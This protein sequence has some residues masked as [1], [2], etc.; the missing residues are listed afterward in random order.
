VGADEYY[1]LISQAVAAT[2]SCADYGFRNN[3]GSLAIFAAI[4]RTS[5]FVSSLAAARSM[6]S[7]KRQRDGQRFRNASKLLH[8]NRAAT[9]INAITILMRPKPIMTRLE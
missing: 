2:T 3:S 9:V 7:L 5:S 4:R 8:Q 6:I 1:R